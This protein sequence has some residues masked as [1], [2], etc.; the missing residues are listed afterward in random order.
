MCVYI[1]TYISIENTIKRDDG[2]KEKGSGFRKMER[3]R[4]ENKREASL[5]RLVL[6]LFQPRIDSVLF[7]QTTRSKDLVVV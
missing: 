5:R 4:R 1:Y 2:S 3:K 6:E 7:V